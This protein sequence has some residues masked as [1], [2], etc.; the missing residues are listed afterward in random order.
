MSAC[1]SQVNAEAAVELA[2]SLSE[3][4]LTPAAFRSFAMS[5]ARHQECQQVLQLF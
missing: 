5:M 3:H 1:A 2:Y 4:G